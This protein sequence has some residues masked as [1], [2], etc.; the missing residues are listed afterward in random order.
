MVF[1]NVP[2]FNSF[3]AVGCFIFSWIG[4]CVAKL[5]CWYVSRIKRN[6]LPCLDSL[7]SIVRMSKVDGLVVTLMVVVSSFRLACNGSGLGVRAGLNARMF[8]LAPKLQKST[9]VQ[10]STFARLTPNPCYLFGQCLGLSCFYI[11]D[12][13]YSPKSFRIV[14]FA[15]S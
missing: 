12:N 14:R 8:N 4:L 10:F 7:C 13:L 6:C 5:V 9:N 15:W 11:S 2:H 3:C 1:V